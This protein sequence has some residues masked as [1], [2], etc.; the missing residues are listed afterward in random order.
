M[1]I[2]YVALVLL[3][4]TLAVFA[5]PTRATANSKFENPTERIH[6]NSNTTHSTY[7][8]LQDYAAGRYVSMGI[9]F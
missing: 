8:S 3:L 9:R 1:K 5:V 4:L 6:A 2:K 7:R